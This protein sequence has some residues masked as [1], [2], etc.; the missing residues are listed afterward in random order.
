MVLIARRSFFTALQLVVKKRTGES[1]N[2]QCSLAK[3]GAAN[4]L[5]S[6]RIGC[7]QYPLSELEPTQ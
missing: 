6:A 2:T 5:K 3:I 1:V 7:L 4:Y